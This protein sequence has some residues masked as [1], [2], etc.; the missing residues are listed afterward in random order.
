M[1]K[2]PIETIHLFP[3]VNQKLV[4]LL[5]SLSP[6]E[7]QLPTVAKM[8]TVK[9]VAAHLLD[10]NTRTV[11]QSRDKYFGEKPP[12]IRSN[13]DLVA[14]LNQLNAAWVNAMKRVSPA[15]LTDWIENTNDAYYQQL[16][17]QDPMGEA[18]FGVSWAGEDTSCNWFHIAREYTEKWHHQQQI[19]DAVNKPGILTK[20]LYHPVLD[21]FMQ[22]LPFTY[23]NTTAAEGTVVRVTVTGE[24]GGDWYLVKTGDLPAGRQDWELGIREGTVPAAHTT[25]DGSVAWKLFSK[26]WRRKEV[27]PFAQTTGDRVLGEVVLDMISVVA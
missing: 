22:A 4:A 20:E 2:V 6:E 3:V 23:R 27:Q 15:V 24:G 25:I 5:R 7:W 12:P 21:T 17:A 19:R 13:D 10:T 16:A 8:W 9:D 1:Q 26:S 11:S 18:I 14:F